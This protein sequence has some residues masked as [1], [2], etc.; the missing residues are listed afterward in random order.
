M[1][2]VHFLLIFV[3]AALLMSGCTLP[4]AS[5]QNPVSNNTAVPVPTASTSPT[6][7]Y[8]APPSYNPQD[9]TKPLI[10]TSSY[11]QKNPNQKLIQSVLGSFKKSD[12]R[13]F[14]NVG[15]LQTLPPE[16][17]DDLLPLL[18]EDNLYTQ[19]AVLEALLAIAP[20]APAS[21]QTSVRA[22]IGPLLSSPRGSIRTMAAELDLSLGEKKGIPVL[23]SSLNNTERLLQSEP[24]ILICQSANEALVAYTDQDFGF[25]CIMGHYDGQAQNKWQAWWNAHQNSLTFEQGKFVG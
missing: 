6:V 17:I 1:R 13:T 20:A 24:P 25:G 19:W 18:K 5:G 4:S 2:L 10:D 15:Q 22:A 14:N 7:Q 23:I 8:P 9:D 3:L 11:P 16:A 21:D 12:A